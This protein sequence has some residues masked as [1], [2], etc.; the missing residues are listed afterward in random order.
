M[1][2]RPRR[3]LRKRSMAR[4]KLTR[5]RELHKEQV[6]RNYTFAGAYRLPPGSNPD[7]CVAVEAD[8]ASGRAQ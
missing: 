5:A 8:R 6:D 3:D 1:S 2:S 4:P 7:G